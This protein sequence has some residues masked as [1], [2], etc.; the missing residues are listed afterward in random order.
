[1]GLVPQQVVGQAPGQGGAA[2][3]QAPSPQA[4][5]TK[6]GKTSKS[7]KMI[8]GCGCGFLLLVVLAIVAFFIVN[9]LLTK[10]AAFQVQGHSWR[11]E[12]PV[13]VYKMSHRTSSCSSMPA[14]AE[15]VKRTKLDP[16]CTTKRVDQGDGTFKEVRDCK[17]RDDECSY[18]I[19]EWKKHRAEQQSGNSLQDNLT[20]PEV[21]LGRTGE[22]EGCERQGA[23]KAT[24]TVKFKDTSGGKAQECEFSDVNKW[25]SFT[26]DSKWKG[27]V[28]GLT[29]S[30]DCD[31]LQKQ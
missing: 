15:R 29:G 6:S 5:G 14:G 8:V 16:V 4:Q 26:V 17:D 25:R 24:Y 3:N 9:S 1:M 31:S 21:R 23:R 28:G 12:I 27:K 22:C 2:S 13:E 10:D 11:H 7:T 30:I 20:W 18:Y 19:G